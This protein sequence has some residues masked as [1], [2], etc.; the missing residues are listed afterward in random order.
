MSLEQ[1]IKELNLYLV[2]WRGYFGRTQQKSLLAK[3]DG[4]VRRRLRVLQLKHWGRSATIYRELRK[5]GMWYQTAWSI[6]GSCGGWWPKSL[7]L[8]RALPRS[9]FDRL[10]LK[11][12]S[13]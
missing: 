5:L 8:S 12:L 9:W 1:V 3:L 6:S 13:V 11:R 2:G 4:Y 10:G 7:R